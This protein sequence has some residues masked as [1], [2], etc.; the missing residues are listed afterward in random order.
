MSDEKMKMYVMWLDTKEIAPLTNTPHAPGQI[1]WSHDDKQLAFTMFVP[2]SAESIVKMPAKP[3]GAKWMTESQETLT[4]LYGWTSVIVILVA[5]C[6][7]FR[8]N[9]VP[10]VRGIYGSTYEV[11]FCAFYVVVSMKHVV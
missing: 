9:V 3:E 11:S 6:A 10:W 1:S 2:K 8:N 7:F 5:S 4:S